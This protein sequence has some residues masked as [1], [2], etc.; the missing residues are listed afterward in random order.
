MHFTRKDQEH[1]KR[2]ALAATKS[3]GFKSDAIAFGASPA[4][5]EPVIAVGVFQSFEENTA[6]FHFG[7]IGEG[8]ITKS[9][10]E[11]FTTIAFHH[12]ALGL[13]RIWTK[14][15]AGNVQAQVAA[16]K[17]GFAF[18]ARLRAGIADG[19]DAIL[20]SIT[21]DLAGGAAARQDSHV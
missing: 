5:G 16:L 20:L 10:V 14:I 1:L 15:E 4:P 7:M 21:R 11:A 13:D 12:A 3:T 17:V 9:L 8:R 18:E 6:E 2:A 19:R